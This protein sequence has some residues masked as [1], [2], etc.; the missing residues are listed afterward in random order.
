M[1]Q[2]FVQGR[3]A[4]SIAALRTVDIE[5]WLTENAT[6][7]GYRHTW[8][9]RLSTLFSFAKR[10]EW[11]TQNPCD[12][13]ERVVIERKRPQILTVEQ[14]KTCVTTIRHEMPVAMGWWALALFCGLRPEEAEKIQ[15]ANIDLKNGIVKVDAA[16]SKVRWRRLVY[17]TPCA[18]KWLTKAKALDAQQPL[19][20]ETRRRALRA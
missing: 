14:A 20:R 17:C 8:I 11:I 4:V 1:L 10:Q 13:V 5:E 19:P 2:K 7:P 9:N 3:E 18:V 12:P 16:A 15:W 6:T